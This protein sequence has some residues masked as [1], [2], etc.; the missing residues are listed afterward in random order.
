MVTGKGLAARGRDL[1]DVALE[2]EQD[3]PAV[4][5]DRRISQPERMVLGRERDGPGQDGGQEQGQE[6]G[7]QNGS[8][9]KSA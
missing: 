2:A 8:G 5:R 1:V 4:G 3:R 9:G 6:S 7:S